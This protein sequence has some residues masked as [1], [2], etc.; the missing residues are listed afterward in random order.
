MNTHKHTIQLELYSSLLPGGVQH[1]VF[2]GMDDTPAQV[3]TTWDEMI[4]ELFD[5]YTVRPNTVTIDSMPELLDHLNGLMAAADKFKD[6]IKQCRVFDREA[7]LAANNGEYIQSNFN[8][9][10]KE[11]DYVEQYNK[12]P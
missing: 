5:M 4:N 8:D 10:V 2:V 3:N 11:I 9:F 12:Q 6:R 1:G 7:W